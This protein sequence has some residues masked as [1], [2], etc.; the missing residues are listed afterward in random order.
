MGRIIDV[1]NE[2]LNKVVPEV[3]RVRFDEVV[4]R[5]MMMLQKNKLRD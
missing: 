5:E 2:V 1:V 4:R 3:G